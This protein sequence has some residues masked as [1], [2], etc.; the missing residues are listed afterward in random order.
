M[1]DGETRGFILVGMTR[2]MFTTLL[3]V[4]VPSCLDISIVLA[5]GLVTMAFGSL[6]F[7]NDDELDTC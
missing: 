2:R 7:R 4:S 5:I 1:E 6:H 3:Q